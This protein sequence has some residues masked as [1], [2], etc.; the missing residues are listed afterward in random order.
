MGR[1]HLLLQAWPRLER[2]TPETREDARAAIGFTQSQEELLAQAGVADR[3]L[4]LAQ[5]V[6]EDE[7]GLR[8]QR[9][10]LWGLETRRAALVLAFAHRAAPAF[11]LS[12]PPGT[13]HAGELVYY[14]SASPLRAIFKTRQ[15]AEWTLPAALGECARME[16]AL[17]AYAGAVAR[18]PWIERFPMLLGEMRFARSGGRWLLLDRERRRAPARLGERAGWQALALTGGRPCM[19]FGEWDGERLDVK[20]V[21]FEG[22]LSPLA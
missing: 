10:W 2:L 8:T 3:W 18:N 9:S 22:R 17:T 20:A 15:A 5:E 16:E 1:L 13:A 21:I 6:E 7:T 19:V 12:L 11:E 14:P 4:A